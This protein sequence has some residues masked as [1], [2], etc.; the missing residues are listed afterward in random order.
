VLKSRGIEFHACKYFMSHYFAV[1]RR[2]A[3]GGD[4]VMT[5]DS[6]LRLN[7]EKLTQRT[8][9]GTD[10]TFMKPSFLLRLRVMIDIGLI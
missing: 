4:G 10:V 1:F 3:V 9:I 8:F 6:F 7:A 5:I 2:W